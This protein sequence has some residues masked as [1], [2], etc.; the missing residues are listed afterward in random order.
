ME[1]DLKYMQNWGKGDSKRL[2]VICSVQ[3]TCQIWSKFKE[4][5]EDITGENNC[6]IS[7]RGVSVNL[8]NI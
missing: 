3:T 1:K 7:F 5:Y 8:M 4:T 2:S 6:V